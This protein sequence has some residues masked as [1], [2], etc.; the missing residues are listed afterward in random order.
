[1]KFVLSLVLPEGATV[2][3]P[4][5]GAS[6]TLGRA[7]TNDIVLKVPEVSSRHLEFVAAE[8]GYRVKDLG[9][10]NGTRVNG[11]RITECPLL[12]GETFLIGERVKGAFRVESAEEPQA[13]V[14]VAVVARPAVKIAKPEPSTPTVV[15]KKSPAAVAPAKPAAASPAKPAVPAAASPAKGPLPVVRKLA[16]PGVPAKPIAAPVKPNPSPDEEGGGPKKLNFG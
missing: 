4:L 2:E 8:G 6:V 11:S 14:A 10:T 15:L 5:E 13:P 3:H 7:A 16:P 1:M 12:G 9:S